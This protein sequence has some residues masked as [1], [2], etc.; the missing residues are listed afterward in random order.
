[1]SK[2]RVVLSSNEVRDYEF[3]TPLAALF[4]REVIG[5]EPLILLSETERN[6]LYDDQ[7]HAVALKAMR[8]HGFEIHFVGHVDGMETGRVG[9]N[10]RQHAAV[11]DIPEDTW[12]MMS[13][14]DLWPLN[15]D[16]HNVHYGFDAKAVCIN[17]YLDNFTSKAEALALIAQGKRFQTI[18]TCM[19]TM[20][21][22]EWREC[23]GYKV[24]TPLNEAVAKTLEDWRI[25]FIDKRQKE[26][27]WR[28]FDIWM[29]DQDIVTY[30]MMRQPWFEKEAKLLQR[31]PGRRLDRSSWSEGSLDTALDA[32][33]FN[34]PDREVNWNRLRLV[35]EKYIPQH[36]AWA[37]AY[38]SDFKASYID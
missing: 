8:H 33:I 26:P 20:R 32:H 35:I 13:D 27:M 25:L 14:A 12:L 30:N 38:R 9:Q 11:L 6:W 36:L 23:Y 28:N 37:D 22:R 17:G 21:A 3:S 24:G 19:V 34:A 10:A 4:W 18:P 15:K 7:R 2:T 16:Y 29:Q 5:H 1:M 31:P